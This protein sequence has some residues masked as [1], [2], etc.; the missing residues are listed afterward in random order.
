MVSHLVR[1]QCTGACAFLSLFLIAGC[2]SNKSASASQSSSQGSSSSSS[3][4]FV[5]ASDQSSNQ[6]SGWLVNGSALT[7]LPGSP[8]A[9]GSGPTDLALS[10]DGHFLYGI[11]TQEQPTV[12]GSACTGSP[13]EVDAWSIDQTTG[14]LTLIQQLPLH[15][16]CGYLSIG[17]KGDYLYVAERALEGAS[18]SGFVEVIGLN[19]ATG[20]M[21]LTSASPYKF[22]QVPMDTVVSG[23]GC[24]AY[25]VEQGPGDS[26]GILVFSR[27]ED[28]GAL[29]YVSTV[30]ATGTDLD[31]LVASPYGNMLY[32]LAE[33][34]GALTTYSIDTTTGNLTLM[35]TTAT[36]ATAMS[37]AADSTGSYVAAAT[38]KGVYVFTV[39]TTGGLTPIKGSPFGSAAVSV[40]FDPPGEHFVALSTDSSGNM[41][42][43]V[44]ALAGAS[45]ALQAT[46]SASSYAADA[47][48]LPQ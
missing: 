47:V 15:E 30:P 18:S 40:N 28:T 36:G 1:L 2:A 29:Q 14:T 26:A 45:A 6:L 44:Y 25:A 19:A 39:G 48:M 43:S 23:C 20:Q 33:D 41:H 38:A 3:P 16:S 5:Y 35:G 11:M 4:S 9:A 42:V 10:A 46:A 34:T 8:Y 27:D 13:D 24:F 12:P 21:T 37:V 17:P 7:A 32:R 31:R 22:A